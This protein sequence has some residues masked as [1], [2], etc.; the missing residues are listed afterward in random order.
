MGLLRFIVKVQTDQLK[1]FNAHNDGERMS[2]FRFIVKLQTDE[3]KTVT[4]RTC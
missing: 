2:L 3:L 4:D 1:P